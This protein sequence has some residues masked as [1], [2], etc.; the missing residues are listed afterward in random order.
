[1]A[2]WPSQHAGEG[3]GDGVV[4]EGEEEGMEAG[5]TVFR[6]GGGGGGYGFLAL[7]L[8]DLEEGG[9]EGLVVVGEGVGVGGGGAADSDGGSLVCCSTCTCVV[10]V[11]GG[12]WSACA[13]VRA[14]CGVGNT[15]VGWRKGW[16]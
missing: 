6:G 2:L 14:C 1:M 5:A 15:H 7:G 12:E 8:K 3:G 11:V 16:N 4:G 13:G 10:V 9:D